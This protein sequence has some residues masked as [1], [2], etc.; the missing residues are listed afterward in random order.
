[1]ANVSKDISTNPPTARAG[2]ASC[3]INLGS[4]LGTWDSGGTTVGIVWRILLR[5]EPTSC[6]DPWDQRYF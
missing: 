2:A 5:W 4:V 3:S 1:M 6:S